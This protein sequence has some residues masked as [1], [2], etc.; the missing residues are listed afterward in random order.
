MSNESKLGLGCFTVFFIA[1]IIWT[2][3]SVQSCMAD[4]GL[5]WITCLNLLGK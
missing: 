2:V 4:L 3:I 5:S 1:A